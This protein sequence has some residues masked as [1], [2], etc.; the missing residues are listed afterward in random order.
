M[1]RTLARRVSIAVSIAAAAFATNTI[2]AQAAPSALVGKWEGTIYAQGMQIPVVITLDSTSAG[3]KGSFLVAML[4]PNAI[5]IASVTVKGDTVSLQ[6][7]E[8]G[9]GAFFQGLLSADKKTLNGMVAVQG[10]N[11]STFQVTKAAADKPP[12][13]LE[14]M[15]EPMIEPKR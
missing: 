9:M 3:W 4:N 7:P 10:D 1:P 8:E 2:G 14:P 5:G 12:A 11:S 6:L 15:I 13:K